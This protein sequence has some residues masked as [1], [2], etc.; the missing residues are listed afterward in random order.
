[1]SNTSPGSPGHSAELT[2]PEM[3]SYYAD[4]PLMW[5][6][7]AMIVLMNLGWGVVFTV[8]NPLI[9]LRMNKLGFAEGALGTL[10]AINSWVYSYMVMYFAWK[11]D[12]TVSRFGRRVPYLFL[13]A[14]FIVAAVVMFP[15]LKWMWVAAGVFLIQA[16][17][18]DIK[19]ATIPLLGIDCMPRRVL[20]RAALPS[21]IAGG[22]LAFFALRYGMRLA[23]W[24]EYAPYFL[25]GI[26]LVV[27]TLVGGFLIREPPV[28]DPTTE[29]FKP[30]SA[31]KVAWQDPR[32]VVLMISVSLF[33]AYLVTYSVWVWLFAKNTLGMTRAETGQAMAWGV[34]AALLAAAPI[35]WLVDRVSPYRL[36]PVFCA[37]LGLHL[38]LVFRIHDVTS[39]MIVA[40]MTSALMPMYN[41]SDIMVYRTA[42]PKVIGSM[43]ST[44]SCLRGLFNGAM[45]AGMGYLIE[46]TGHNYYAAFVVAYGLQLLG[47]VALF[48]YR[49]LMNR[50][51][52]GG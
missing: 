40:C 48:S 21:T 39:L 33:Q 15:F 30:W 32:R 18:M 50:K 38:F 12:H 9:Q 4:R 24:N 1:M 17:F 8:V 42:D 46:H 27:T 43:T 11:S 52:P 37:L 35:A 25:G 23:E 47:L 6:N 28:R 10:G 29:R 41:A 49:F 19:A 2:S 44:N 20:A 36:L 22:I 3:V 13:S 7:L 45:A 31:M 26:V 51:S 14:P 34:L 16:F 5:R